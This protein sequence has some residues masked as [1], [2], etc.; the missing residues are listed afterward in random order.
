MQPERN[1]NGLTRQI[2]TQ[3]QKL[4]S[5][6][7]ELKKQILILQQQINLS[8]R[9]TLSP[10]SESEK[11]ITSRKGL[12][13]S[14]NVQIELETNPD[15]R[16]F[17]EWLIE[18]NHIDEEGNC[19]LDALCQNRGDINAFDF[20]IQ[21]FKDYRENG[22][23]VYSEYLGSRLFGVATKFHRAIRQRRDAHGEKRSISELMPIKSMRLKE[24]PIDKDI[25]RK[26]QREARRLEYRIS[27]QNK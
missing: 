14:E 9:N 3:I 26:H 15:Y 23:V 20:F 13:A 12:F 17:I 21:T 11:I 7:A 25:I 1:Q 27:K 8:V 16:K 22:G 5:E 6:N 2:E 4:E 24:L 19:N 18:K 10:T